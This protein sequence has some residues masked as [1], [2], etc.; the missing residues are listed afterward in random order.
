MSLQLHSS[1]LFLFNHP[2]PTQI[3]TLSL[4]DALPIS[5]FVTSAAELAAPVAGLCAHAP[6]AE[7]SL[8]PWSLCQKPVDLRRRQALV[9][10]ATGLLD[11]QTGALG[12]I[13]EGGDCIRASMPRDV[14]VK[15]REFLAT[16]KSPHQNGDFPVYGVRVGH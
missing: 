5:V 13:D 10:H 9:E 7:L 12:V 3:Y 4:H 11:A 15:W 8:L 14:Q 1:P 6:P 2:A 16:R